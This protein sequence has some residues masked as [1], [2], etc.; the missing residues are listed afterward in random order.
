MDFFRHYN[1]RLTLDYPGIAYRVD[2]IIGQ[3]EVD[4][5]SHCGSLEVY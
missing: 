5:F 4:P 3:R 2:P 1:V